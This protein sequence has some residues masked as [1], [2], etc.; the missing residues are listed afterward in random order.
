MQ[1][2]YSTNLGG[3]GGR[4]LLGGSVRSGLGGKGDTLESRGDLGVVDN[5]ESKERGGGGGAAKND[6]KG[7]SHQIPSSHTHA[8]AQHN[9]SGKGFVVVVGAER[10]THV[11]SNRRELGNFFCSSGPRNLEKASARTEA[12]VMSARVIRSP[13]RKVLVAR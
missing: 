13:M 6:M 7:N 4:L 12:T 8:R 3:L 2:Y 11:C 10:I 9:A 1:G 5:A